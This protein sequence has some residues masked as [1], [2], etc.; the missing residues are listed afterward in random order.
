MTCTSSMPGTGLAVICDHIGLPEADQP[1]AESPAPTMPTNASVAKQ[2]TDR[3]ALKANRVA[4]L[5][6]FGTPSSRFAMIRLANGRVKKVQV[7]DMIDGGRI[8]GIT[9][10]T[11]QYQKGSRVVTLSLPQG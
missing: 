7:G 5:A 9:A 1:Q 11:V 6:V 2:A 8:A 4:L 3:N 10:D